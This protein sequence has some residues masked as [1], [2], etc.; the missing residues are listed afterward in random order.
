MLGAD[1]VRHD[2]VAL[3]PDLLGWERAP[4]RP[5]VPRPRPRR[6]L[7]AGGGDLRPRQRPVR[8]ARPRRPRCA[9]PRSHGAARR[10]RPPRPRPARAALDHVVPEGHVRLEA[11][12]GP[13]ARYRSFLEALTG[14]ARVV[15]GTRA[16][17]FAPLP[18]LGLVAVL[19][20]GD[21]SHAEQRAPYPHV[22]EVAGPARRAGRRR[23]PLRRW[24]R[25]AE[26]Q[27]LLESGWPRPVPRA[28]DTVRATA[29]R[30]AIAGPPAPT[31]R[32]R[33][34]QPRDCQRRRWRVLRDAVRRGPVLVQVPRTGTCRRWPARPAA[35]RRGAPRATARWPSPT[36]GSAPRAAGAAGPPPTGRAGTAGTA[37]S[38][39]SS[40]GPAAR[41]RSSAARSPAWTSAPP[42]GRTSWTSS[43]VGPPWS[44]PRRGQN[45]LR[46][47]GTPPHCCSTGGRCSRGPD[48]RAAEE[49]Y[50]RWTAAAAAG[51]AGLGRRCRR[52]VAD[53]Q[54]R[55]RRRSCVGT[56]PV[57]AERE[58]AQRRELD[59]PPAARFAGLIGPARTSRS[60]SPPCRTCPGCGCSDRC[61]CRTGPGRR[62]PSAAS[63]ASRASTPPNWRPP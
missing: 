3:G 24:T 38:A 46:R 9:R 60:S 52:P 48:L 40:R 62:P 45:P 57:F 19:E 56:R 41:P 55:P 16:A 11:D 26:T 28:A 59:L 39:P 49:A 5:G 12:L 20:D 23:G 6:A 42:A 50:R 2:P 63:C 15:A 51:A 29:P 47:R 27:L 18:N 1:P 36:R 61:R 25:T 13:A 54:A 8:P 44:S 10:P 32:T 34:P 58:L 43:P 14:R 7:P 22:R 4:G 53:P 30:V 21:D 33:W 35:N 17:V 31:R 37:G